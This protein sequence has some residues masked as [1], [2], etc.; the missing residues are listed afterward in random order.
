MSQG[1]TKNDPER[2]IQK[3]VNSKLA[4]FLSD[5]QQ[6]ILN[7]Q[8]VPTIP[9][10]RTKPS[11]ANKLINPMENNNMKMKANRRRESTC[12]TAVEGGLGTGV[13]PSVTFPIND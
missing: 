13:R 9:Y 7:K 8:G 5:K 1:N 11:N 12:W 10:S 6:M 3:V 4:V 2:E